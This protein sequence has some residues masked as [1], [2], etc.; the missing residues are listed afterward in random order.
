M[1]E[2]VRTWMRKNG[3][4]VVL[5]LIAMLA[6]LYL[7][8]DVV[9]KRASRIS[10]ETIPPVVQRD[11]PTQG[12][13]EP[14][15]TIVEFGEFT[16]EVCK[17]QVHVLKDV[18]NDFGNDVQVV[19]KD[20]PLDPLNQQSYLS[21]IS[22]QCAARQGK[23]WE[24]HDAMFERQDELNVNIYN[25]IAAELELNTEEFSSC[26]SKRETD[27]KVQE[28]IESA[29]AAQITS[30]PTFF[31]NGVKYEGYLEYQDVVAALSGI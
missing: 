10:F 26:L 13:D 23:F 29:H 18:I 5:A 8:D 17:V 27:G 20:A 6:L 24:M 30:T 14:V 7:G 4:L 11:D 25:E 9:N 31:I 12:T 16:C 19:W 21:S 2:R 3:P 1:N 22:G 15:A 28:N